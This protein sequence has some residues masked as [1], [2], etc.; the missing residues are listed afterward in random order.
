MDTPSCASSCNPPLPV[1]VPGTAGDNGFTTVTNVFTVPAQFASVNVTVDNAAV[2]VLNQ[3]VFVGSYN[4]NGANF[5]VTAINSP[6]SVT[7]EYLG[8]T[9]DLAA[10]S[11][12]AAGAIIQPGTGNLPSY[13]SQL[14]VLS[15]APFTTPI[16]GTSNQLSVT[17]TVNFTVGQNIYFGGINWIITAINTSTQI[18]ILCAALPPDL[19]LLLSGSFTIPTGSVVSA[20]VGNY[21]LGV[22]GTSFTQQFS[23]SSTIGST[24]VANVVSSAPFAVGQNAFL[25]D[26]G[27][28][29]NFLVTAIPSATQVTLKLLGFQ[30]DT[31]G[32]G[33]KPGRDF[34][35]PGTANITT[36]GISQTVQAAG[37]AYGLTASMAQVSFGTTSPELTMTQPGTYLFL[38]TARV[39]LAAADYNAAATQTV[40]LKLRDVTGGND[41]SGSQTSM[42]FTSVNGTAQTYTLKSGALPP[43]IATVASGDSVALFGQIGTVPQTSGAVNVVE[44]T[45]TAV[46]LY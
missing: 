20:G 17:T 5:L 8:Y 37:T 45:I 28:V 16:P 6:T 1:N 44:A 11:A 23:P 12:I 18:T 19:A 32:L 13:A 25:A 33:G 2:M 9:G 41:L 42:L 40:T 21:D 24:T 15:T 35:Y 31:L 4:T 38:A 30:G 10:G 26:G 39:D 34:L 14:A 22:A 43:V 46:R 36:F 7:L 3:N 29:T 27:S